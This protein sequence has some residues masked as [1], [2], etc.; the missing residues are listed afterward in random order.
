MEI[1]DLGALHLLLYFAVPG[2][3]TLSVYR[4]YV[5][6]EPL[7]ASKAGLDVLT[8]SFI[9]FGF[10]SGWLYLDDYF[11]LAVHHPYWHALLMLIA[12]F[13]A[14]GFLGY[15]LYKFDSSSLFAVH[16][17]KKPWDYV[18][19][20]NLEYWLIAETQDGRRIG[21]VFGGK[22]FASSFPS[23]EQVYLEQEWELDGRTFVK[24]VER[25]AGVIIS[26]SDIRKIELYR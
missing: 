18:F 11:K 2:F 19:S 5:A 9:N 15:A 1:K 3:I 6:S 8:Y 13:I 10:M 4:R 22:S 25:S 12:L 26:G 17:V 16:P 23:P 24:P 14:P 7:D 21:G 20:R